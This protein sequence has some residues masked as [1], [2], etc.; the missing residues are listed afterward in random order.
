M[1]RYAQWLS[2]ILGRYETGANSIE[3]GPMII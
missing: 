2:D 3:R 1:M